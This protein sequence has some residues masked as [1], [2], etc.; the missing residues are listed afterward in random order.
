MEANDIILFKSS[1]GK[2]HLEVKQEGESLWL[3]QEQ[4]AELFGKDVSGVSRHITKI[5]KD[6]ELDEDSDVQ[7]MHI[8]QFKPVN[9]YSL[10]SWQNI[11]P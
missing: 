2:I 1:D 5:F 3:R 9:F 8:T 10:E 7:K 6:G 11:N 4:I